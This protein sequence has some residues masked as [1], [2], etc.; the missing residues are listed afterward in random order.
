MH[1]VLR[2]GLLLCL[3]LLLAACPGTLRSPPQPPK[4]GEAP[5][6]APPQP[7]ADLRGSTLYELVGPQ[8]Q[9][10]IYVYRAGAFSRM[11]HNHVVSSRTLS[12]RAWLHP[13]FTRSGFELSL[14]VEQFVVD[15]PQARRAAGKEF[16]PELSAQDKEATRRNMLGP[17]VLDAARYPTIAV[18]VAHVAG[19][20]QA[21]QITARVTIKDVTRDV[22]VPVRLAVEDGQLSAKGE[23]ELQQTDFGI[24]PYS[25]MLGALAVQDRLRV[26]FDLL[27][28]R[29][30]SMPKA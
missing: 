5:A 7:P 23:F 16:P 17:E 2:S 27:F 10:H 24:K 13:Q 12:A 26:R 4:P 21:P 18:H 1:H 19:S 25:V 9:V 3:A 14:P 6:S 30:S 29:T 11:G 28:R 22:Q 20:L 8:S 15:D